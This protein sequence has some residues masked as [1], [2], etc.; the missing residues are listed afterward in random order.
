MGRRHYNY[1]RDYEP[2]TGRYVESDPIGLDGGL[3]TYGYVEGSPLLRF[4]RF[5]LTSYVNFPPEKEA[6]MKRAV[7]EAKQKL[8]DCKGKPHCW[9]ED[10]TDDVIEKLDSANFVYRPDMSVCGEAGRFYFRRTIS[11]SPRAFVWGDCCDLSS[12]LAHEANHLGRPW[13]NGG[14]EASR[15][16]ETLCFNCPRPK[17]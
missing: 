8:R 16:L 4:D 15:E 7:E 14:E 13:S 6:E 17:R 5:G 9:S 11:I 3:S 1:F 10:E 12:T 2:G